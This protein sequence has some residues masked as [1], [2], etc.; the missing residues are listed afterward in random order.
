MT[1]RRSFLVRSSAVL[2]ALATTRGVAADAAATVPTG[3]GRLLGP[4]PAGRWDSERVSN[5]CVLRGDDGLWRMWYYGRDPSFT[6]AINMPT[7]RSGLATSRDGLK[8]ERVDGPGTLGAVLDP[9]GDPRRFD[10]AHVG[11]SF[12]ERRGSTWWMW[13]FGGRMAESSRAGFP[14]RPG[15]ALSGD[16]LHWSRVEG[17]YGGAMLDVGRPGEPDEFMVGWPQVLQAPDG[18]FRMYYHTRARQ[19]FLPMLAV[20]EDGFRWQ[21]RGVI[22]QPGDTGS[23]DAAGIATRTV[24]RLRDRWLMLYE[25]VAPDLYRGIGL[26]ESRDGLSWRKLRGAEPNGSAFAH[27]PRGSGLWDARGLGCPS[28][29]VMPDGGLRMYYIGSNELPPGAEGELATVHQIGLAVSADGDP[30][31]WRRWNA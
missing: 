16:G 5:P 17:P 20:S 27:A 9:S 22:L 13:Y 1:D 18:S 23:F 8:W 29:V 19:A 30:A 6:R 7:G 25:G 12:V 31:R 3:P 28:V 11:V 4:G 26:A 15:L 2:G 24:F 21:K 14:M 10:E